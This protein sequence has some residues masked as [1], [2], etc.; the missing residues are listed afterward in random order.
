MNIYT[1]IILFFIIAVYLVETVAN[2]LNVKNISNNIPPEFDGYF[3]REKYSKA[4]EYLKANTKLSVISSTFFLA[5]QIIFI[6]LKGFNYVNTIAV[7]FSFGTILT[8]LVFAGIVFSAF[9][10][11]K[12]PFSVYSVF[13]IEENFG[14]NKMNVKTF[15]S[16][17]L[18]SWIITAIIGAVIFAAI[19]WLFANVYRYAWLYA[20]AAI[21]IFEL[22]ITFIAPVTIMPL[23]NKYTSLEDGELKN[24]IEE[25]AKKENFKMKGLFKMDG[26]KRST[27]S[28]AFFTGFGKFRRIV[29]F[30]TLIQKHTVDGLTSILAHEMGH[31]KLGH[32]VKHIIFSSA[33]SGIMLFI[34]SLLIDKAWL[35]D[36]FF[37]RTQDIYAGIIFF[38]F[39]Y[40]PVSLIISPILN[41]FSRKHEYEADLYS[42]TTYRK[43]QA[44]INALKKLSVDNMSN[45]YPHK[46]KVFLE[47]SHPPVLERIKAIN[48]IK[49]G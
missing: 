8:G 43:P 48:R 41:Y 5:A 7:S 3:D 35:Y 39:L 2:L 34:F 26:S 18:K 6:V 36:A 32:I 24:S 49:L 1:L 40:A 4:Q 28:N 21:V 13:I 9:E 12:I 46:F 16:D 37:M 11:L 23:F 45:L 31:F 47:Y 14:F 33:L 27:K 29:L 25:Y 10:I 30:D 20:F 19:L 38:S 22:F 15:I 42:I 17:L 44:M